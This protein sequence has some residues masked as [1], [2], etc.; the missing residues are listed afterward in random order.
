MGILGRPLPGRVAAVVALLSAFVAAGYVVDRAQS[1]DPTTC[2][3]YTTESGV[4]QQIVNGAG[5]GPRIAVIGDSYSVGLQLDH[6]GTSWPSR[7]PGEVHVYGF[8]GSGFAEKS[9]PCGPV[10]YADRAGR[11]LRSDPQLVVV[12]GGLNDY[13]QPDAAVNDGV[14]RLLTAL[15][16]HQVVLV[17]PPDAPARPAAAHVDELLAASAADAGVPYIATSDVDFD[18]L[19]GGLHLTPEGHREFGELVAEALP[20]LG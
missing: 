20:E 13:D 7:L 17:G 5:T 2:E 1:E 9:S 15:E 3:R 16:G 11:A 4:R 6:V 18:Y 14:R 10:S 8:S 12:Q 19:E